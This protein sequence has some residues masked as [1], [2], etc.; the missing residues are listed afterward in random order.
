MTTALVV[1]AIAAAAVAVVRQLNT[2][3][4]RVTAWPAVDD[5]TDR[6]DVR[7]RSDLLA[8]RSASTSGVARP[9]GARRASV[10]RRIAPPT[11]RAA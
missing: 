10:G 9:R 4:R 6:D 8:A 11:A 3:H 5:G 2:N 7:A 1:L